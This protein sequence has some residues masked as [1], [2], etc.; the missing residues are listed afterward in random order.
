MKK[1]KVQNFMGVF[2]SKKKLPYLI[3]GKSKLLNSKAPNF[4]A[5]I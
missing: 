2:L 5:F 3:F 4:G 1:K